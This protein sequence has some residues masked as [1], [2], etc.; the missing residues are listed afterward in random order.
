MLGTEQEP[1]SLTSLS[2]HCLEDVEL[3]FHPLLAGVTRLVVIG[4]VDCTEET[5]GGVEGEAEGDGGAE[6]VEGD[7]GGEESDT[8]SFGNPWDVATSGPLAPSGPSAPFDEPVSPDDSDFAA[9]LRK[10]ALLS[11]ILVTER[12]DPFFI[13]DAWP[14]SVPDARAAL[15]AHLGRFVR[16]LMVDG[17]TVDA[18]FVEEL[19][20]TLPGI[21]NIS[22]LQCHVTQ[23]GIDALTNLFSRA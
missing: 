14:R 23:G 19:A 1:C 21:R 22:C 13:L 7:D 17:V 12:D 18:Q 5:E 6:G 11:R 4:C 10:T 9:L 20:Q 8:D 2:L 16:C 15:G 3:L